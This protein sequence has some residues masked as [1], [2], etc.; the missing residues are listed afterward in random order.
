LEE[1]K[2]V[3]EADKKIIIGNETVTF[4]ERVTDKNGNSITFLSTKGPVFN[5][6]NELIGLFGIAKDI[7]DRIRYEE[8][9]TI[10]SY[11]DPLTGLYNRRFFEEELDRLDVQRNLP[12]A[13]VL[14]DVN[15]L[16]LTNDA[17][18]HAVGD[19]LLIK[20]A[21]VLEKE[22]RDDDIIARVGGDEFVIILP[23][24]D[25][26]ETESF[27]TRI[28]A[29]IASESINNVELSVSCGYKIKENVNQNIESV[30]KNADNNM[31]RQKLFESS[32]VHYNT[33]TII[34][35]TLFEK[36][37]REEKHSKRV[38]QLSVT[39][40]EALGLRKSKTKELM[41]L[42]LMHDIGKIAIGEDILN[43]STSL[44]E[45]EWLE[46]KRHPEIGFNILKSVLDYNF[47]AGYV[48]SHHERWDGFGYPR[49][50]K[51]TNIPL[52]SRIIAIVDSFDAMTA[53]R[54]YRDAIDQKGA[55]L[56]LEKNSGTQFDPELVKVFVKKMRVTESQE[57]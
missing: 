32:S 50:L 1:A 35:K 42:G 14:L 53:Y 43:R 47:L 2:V 27:V 30:F 45:L 3:M 6:N 7:S 9:L 20:V 21:E 12:L 37:P 56:E 40:G 49:G 39:L 18:G 31:Y 41:I 11:H 46:I 5:K 25:L 38:S 55:L 51:G 13:L 44:N 24:T 23:K 8:K 15:G 28:E 34:M 10:L 4:E 36:N 19:K 54:P 16:K 26:T 22:C 33:V 48:L 52:E 17:F 57:K 29:Q